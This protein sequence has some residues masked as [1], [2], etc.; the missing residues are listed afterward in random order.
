MRQDQ[1]NRSRFPVIAGGVVLGIAAFEVINS[2]VRYLVGPLISL[3]VGDSHFDLNS[4]TV[5]ATEFR[6]G[7]FIEALLVVAMVVLVTYLAFPSVVQGLQRAQV[8]QKEC[9]ECRQLVAVD[10]RR[11]PYCTSGLSP[12][13]SS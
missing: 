1:I 5:E 12:Q 6:Y 7:A 2:F 10:A 8:R 3:L 9:P 4:F 11:C 13:V